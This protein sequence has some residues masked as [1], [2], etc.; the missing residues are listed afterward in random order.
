MT[1][2]PVAR[3]LYESSDQLDGA[4]RKLAMGTV[5]LIELAQSWVDSLIDETS[6][7]GNVG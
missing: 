1:V 4:K 3:R 5:Q 2:R 6:T 7:A